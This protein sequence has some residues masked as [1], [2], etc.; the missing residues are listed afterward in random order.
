MNY[1]SG[2]YPITESCNSSQN[3]IFS[4]NKWLCAHF[5]SYNTVIFS[6]YVQFLVFGSKGIPLYIKF[7][8]HILDTGKDWTF[9]HPSECGT[10]KGDNVLRGQNHISVSMKWNDSFD[11]REEHWGITL[12]ILSKYWSKRICT[13][14]GAVCSK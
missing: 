2:M 9:I 6:K 7:A 11:I 3:Y 12:D 5:Y 10:Y 8:L 14:E 1:V 4:A 13:Y